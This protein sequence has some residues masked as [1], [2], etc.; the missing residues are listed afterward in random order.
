MRKCIKGHNIRKVAKHC[1]CI[2]QMNHTYVKIQIP[3]ERKYAM[4]AFLGLCFLTQD[5]CLQ[6]LLLTCE[7][8]FLTAE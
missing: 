1:L 7:H 5:A 2:F 4:F 8:H 6:V 3:H